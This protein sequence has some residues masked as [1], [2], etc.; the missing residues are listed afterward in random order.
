MLFVM[1]SVYVLVVRLRNGLEPRVC[2]MLIGTTPAAAATVAGAQAASADTCSILMVEY[3]YV[4]VLC[5]GVS[6]ELVLQTKKF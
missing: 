1:T 3:V 2:M 4:S 5:A 6:R